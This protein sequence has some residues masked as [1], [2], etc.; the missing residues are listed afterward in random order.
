MLNYQFAILLFYADNANFVNS[1][2]PWFK[3]GGNYNNTT[4]SGAFN[5]NNNNGGSNSNNG[6]RLVLTN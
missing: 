6:F 1:S 2:N 4:N 3:R 5:F